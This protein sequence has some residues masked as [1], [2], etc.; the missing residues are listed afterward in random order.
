VCKRC[1]QRVWVRR[2]AVALVVGVMEEEE[3]EEE[4]GGGGGGGGGE[5]RLAVASFSSA[6]PTTKAHPISCGACLTILSSKGKSNEAAASGMMDRRA[7]SCGVMVSQAER[8]VLLRC[9]CIAEEEMKEE[10]KRESILTNRKAERGKNGFSL[11][12]VS[13]RLSF[14]FFSSSSPPSPPPSPPPPA[15]AAA[16]K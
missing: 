5:E 8:G 12:S 6:H 11:G 2:R 4:E 3:G 9:A 7:R 15:A 13:P 16:C 1:D 14:S 10:E